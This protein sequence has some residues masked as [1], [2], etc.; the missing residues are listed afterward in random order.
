MRYLY[1]LCLAALPFSLFSQQSD[2][3]DIHH[4]FSG[5]VT[6]THNGIS[7]I[8][9]FSLDAPALI[10]NLKVGGD[11]FS[12]EPDLRMSLDGKPWSMLFWARYRALRHERVSLRLGIHPA[13]NFR[14]IT[15]DDGHSQRDLLESRRYVATEVVPGYRV[16]DRLSVG[17]YY[18]LGHGFDA[19][20]RRS[21]FV[22]LNAAVTG[23][24]LPDEFLLDLFPQAYYLRTDALDGTYLA[25]GW[26]L[27]RAGLSFAL[28]GLVN[29]SLRTEIAPERKWIWNVALEWSFGG[30]Y[31]LVRP[32]I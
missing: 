5:R 22:Q 13:L 6:V 1:F 28:S 2:T 25:G 21:H 29:R 4:E 18:L 15:V 12:F 20:L 24:R 23:I 17:M 27:S 19:G 8:P 14:T 3:T 9:S 26:R 16:N 30:E 7:I 10:V 31:E 32:S 11:R